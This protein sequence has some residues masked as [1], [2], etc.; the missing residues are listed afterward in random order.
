MS[1]KKKKILDWMKA[2]RNY[3]VLALCI[4]SATGT[5]ALLQ[6]A[7]VP[8]VIP[9][10]PQKTQE[11][12]PLPDLA[13]YFPPELEP[14]AI[15]EN[16]EQ[17]SQETNEPSV[18]EKVTEPESVTTTVPNTQTPKAPLSY[19]FPV[20]GNIIKPFSGNTLV[21]SATLEDW[22]AHSGIDIQAP[23]GTNVV[24]CADGIVED[25]LTDDR[26]GI[27]IVLNHQN[28]IRS[29]YS[30]LSSGLLVEVGQAV[31]AGEVISSIGSS[32]LY[33]AAD[34]SH[35]HFEMRSGDDTIDPQSYLE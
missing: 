12:A 25:I 23:E 11:Q 2:K 5:Y 6:R 10:Q 28:G 29:V 18:S 33:E 34:E 19:R 7:S 31:A 27:T 1:E 30:N 32:A 9:E 4:L 17:Q 20:D 16:R 15:R 22:R 24:A 21:Y 35:L 8:Q 14:S 13:E 3:I 26:M